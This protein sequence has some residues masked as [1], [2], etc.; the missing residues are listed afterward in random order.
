M[1]D[2]KF[3]RENAD[4]IT[5]AGKKKHIEFDVAKLLEVDYKRGLR[6]RYLKRFGR[7]RI[8][9]PTKSRKLPRKNERRLSQNRKQ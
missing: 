5:L 9:F 2:I 3:I 4:L 1:L 8:S 7:I 6:F